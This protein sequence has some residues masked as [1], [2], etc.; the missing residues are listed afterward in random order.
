MRDRRR[1]PERR[2]RPRR[3]L[4]VSERALYTVGMPARPPAR[5]VSLPMPDTIPTPTEVLSSIDRARA[6]SS[7][8]TKALELIHNYGRSQYLDGYEKGRER[9]NVRTLFALRAPTEVP[10]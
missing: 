4:D 1:G 8:P 7:D 6:G 9:D 3:L 10:E 5:K 2:A